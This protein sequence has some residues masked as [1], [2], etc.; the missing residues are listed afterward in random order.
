MKINMTKE[1]MDK[2]YMPIQVKYMINLART[3]EQKAIKTA[4]INPKID[5]ARNKPKRSLRP[6]MV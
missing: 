1:M 4:A 3:T 2:R 6:K 5:S